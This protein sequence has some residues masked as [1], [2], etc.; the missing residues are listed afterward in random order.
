MHAMILSVT[1]ML[2]SGKALP[3]AKVFGQNVAQV[4]RLPDN[5]CEVLTRAEMSTITGLDVTAV[6][7]EPSIS[8]M[9][10]AQREN[11]KAGPGA[12]CSYETRSGFGAITISV[13]PRAERTNASYW[14]FRAKYFEIYRG[15]AQVISGLGRDAWLAGG[16]DLHVLVQQD[17]YFVLSTQLHQRQSRELLVKIAKAIVDRR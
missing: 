10:R 14:A 5:P 13:P 1:L 7:R 6:R 3:A 16:A 17:E 12:I 15:S 11:R 2:L 9:V 4:V 8:K